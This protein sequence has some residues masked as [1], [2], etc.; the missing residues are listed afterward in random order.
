MALKD[1]WRPRV[2]NVDVAD[3]STVNEIADAV[4]EL[5]ENELSSEQLANINKIPSIEQTAIGASA[6]AQVALG[7]AGSAY[8]L[9]SGKSDKPTVE[10]TDATE[11]D[12]NFDNRY[13]N[14]VRCTNQAVTWI[15]FNFGID[16][17]DEAYHADISFNSGE[18]PTDIEYLIISDVNSEN[19]SQVQLINWVGTDCV[20]D[21]YENDEGQLVPVS[22]F[23]PSAYTHY[24]IVFYFNGTQ[25]IGLVN[26]FVPASGNVV[27][28]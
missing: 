7:T 9:A 28:E 17:Y 8:D 6:D 2:D 27:S 24:D 18:T 16:A 15:S 11:I 3:S 25:M 23:Q 12:F 21:Y 13:N 14:V 4:I 22:I 19:K 20:L 10:Y 26:G 5:E 1:I